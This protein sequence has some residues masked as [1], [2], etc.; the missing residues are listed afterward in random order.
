MNTI[1]PDITTEVPEMHTKVN[2]GSRQGAFS[3]A[4]GRSSLPLWEGLYFARITRSSGPAVGLGTL[5]IKMNLMGWSVN[6]ARFGND[7]I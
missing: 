5:S 1:V 7:F 4:R 2:S 6:N 3:P